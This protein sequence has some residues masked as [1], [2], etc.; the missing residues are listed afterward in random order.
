MRA[1]APTN[2]GTPND[3]LSEERNQWVNVTWMPHAS[4]SQTSH[5][6]IAVRS[7]LTSLD[8]LKHYEP[9][10]WQVRATIHG[11]AGVSI[12]PIA[13]I[14]PTAPVTPLN[15]LNGQ[16]TSTLTDKGWLPMASGVTHLCKLDT[17]LHISLRW[18]DLP[19]DAYLRFE[20]VEHCDDVVSAK[21]LVCMMR[22]FDSISQIFPIAALRGN[23]SNVHGVRKTPH[24]THAP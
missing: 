20:V 16:L 12:V 17:L 8:E 15:G 10:E 6:C 5:V 19:R 21:R 2:A 3:L 22:T 7:V 23:H 18:R 9:E 11:L 24:W 13:S 4:L 1:R 14:T